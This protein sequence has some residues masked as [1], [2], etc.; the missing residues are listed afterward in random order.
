M[1]LETQTIDR[2]NNCHKDADDSLA[3]KFRNSSTRLACEKEKM[4]QEMNQV[5]Q[6]F[7]FLFT[8]MGV[9][10]AQQSTYEISLIYF[11]FV[12]TKIEML[13]SHLKSIRESS[14]SKGSWDDF[15]ECCRCQNKET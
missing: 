3:L 14:T 15:V 4:L 9:C 7:Y 10:A 2:K 8:I 12:Q 6:F 13:V 5:G 11:V 1:L